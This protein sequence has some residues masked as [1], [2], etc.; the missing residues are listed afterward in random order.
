MSEVNLV[1]QIV[2]GQAVKNETTK[3]KEAVAG[4]ELG[5]DAFLQLLVTQMQNQDP[6]EPTSNSDYIAQL[7]TYSQV[8]ELQ[9]LS[10]SI[11]TIQ[12]MSMVGKK[13]DL[14]SELSTGDKV[15]VTGK[16]DSVNISNG[17]AYVNVNGSQYEA[18]KVTSI[19][20]SNSDDVKEKSDKESD[21]NIL[22]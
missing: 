8:E 7:A 1:T 22:V 9:N 20:D 17:T 13:V 19:Y 12:A 2:D 14:T 11:S 18:S 21:K 5:K 3:Q 16:V 4:G 6:L 10:K 15:T